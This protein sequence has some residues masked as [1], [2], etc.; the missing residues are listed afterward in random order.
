MYSCFQRY[1][2]WKKQVQGTMFK[3]LMQV[4]K[5]RER[6]VCMCVC[7]CVYMYLCVKEEFHEK[8]TLIA[9]ES[10]NWLLRDR[11]G[12]KALYSISY[13]SK[14]LNSCGF[15]MYLKLNKSKLRKSLRLL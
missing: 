10:G 13:S 9:C 7:E 6:S 12:K 15:I 2:T 3:V 11:S 14:N 1:F 5:A 4:Q 8:L